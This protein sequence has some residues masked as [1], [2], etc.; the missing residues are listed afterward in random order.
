[1]QAYPMLLFNG[2][3]VDQ[4]FGVEKAKRAKNSDAQALA[5]PIAGSRKFGVGF[6]ERGQ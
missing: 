1:M 4:G 2:E 5:M 6:L 3:S